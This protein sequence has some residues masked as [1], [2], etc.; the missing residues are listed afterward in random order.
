[1]VGIRFH[2]SVGRTIADT[3]YPQLTLLNPNAKANNL[4][5]DIFSKLIVKPT[6]QAQIVAA[7]RWLS[8]NLPKLSKLPDT[9]K[10]SIERIKT[11]KEGKL[12]GAAPVSLRQIERD[13][14]KWLGITPKHLQ[15]VIRVHQTLKVLKANPTLSLADVAYINGFTDQAHMTRELQ[16]M[17]QIT[18]RRYRLLATNEAQTH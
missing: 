4:Y 17:A 3:Q 12:F 7:Y 9:L 13:F 5:K 1:M 2:P 11:S 18:P 14:K 8:E 16:Q 15:R 6:P 10:L